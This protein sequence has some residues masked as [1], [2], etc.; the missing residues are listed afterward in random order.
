MNRRTTDSGFNYGHIMKVL[1]V[2]KR[3]DNQLTLPV[4]FTPQQA[5]A[6]LTEVEET[7]RRVIAI[8]QA[9]EDAPEN[10]MTE[11]MVKLER[12]MQKLEDLGCVLKDLSQ[13]LVDFPAVRLGSRVWL[14]WKL[15][16]KSVTFWHGLKDG[17]AGRQRAKEDDFYTDDVAIKSLAREVLPKPQV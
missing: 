12:E 11:S 9:T 1:I 14:C 7:V 2:S 5:N 10:K 4:F 6:A 8:K 13:G 15:G 16:E 17:F 3:E